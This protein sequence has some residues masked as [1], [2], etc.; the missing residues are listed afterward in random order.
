MPPLP[1]FLGASLA[2]EAAAGAVS[3][4]GPEGAS[5]GTGAGVS[6]AGAVAGASA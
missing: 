6:A 2:D 5:K 4:T 1:F 3:A